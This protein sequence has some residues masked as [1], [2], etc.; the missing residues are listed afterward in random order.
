MEGLGEGV[1]GVNGRW[2]EEWVEAAGVVGEG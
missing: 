2:E 1:L